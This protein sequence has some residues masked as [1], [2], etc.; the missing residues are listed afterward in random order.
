[1]VSKK[2]MEGSDDGSNEIVSSV[3]TQEN[4]SRN[5]RKFLSEFPLD[6]PIDSPALSLTE[7]PRYE[8]L[9]E[10]LQNTLNE[11]ASLD[12]QSGQT[13]E[14]REIESSQQADWDDPVAC[15]LEKLLISNL[16]A[17]F[18]SAIKKIVE[19]GYSQELAEL[20]VLRSGLYHG[21]KDVVSNVVDGALALLTKERYLG[22]R[23]QVF[24][25]FDSLIEY[26]ILEMICV[27]R[28]V[29]PF[30]TVAEA[31]WYL[32]ICDLNLLHACAVKGDPS[33]EFFSQVN[34]GEGSSD[35]KVPQS[36]TEVS[37]ASSNN[38]KSHLLK[39]SAT[40][41]QS[42]Q[43]K[44]AAS[45]LPKN[46]RFREVAIT[47]KEGSVSLLEMEG[48]SLGASVSEEKSGAG[49][50]GSS[51]L[52]KKDL[53]RQ[54][55][56][57]FEKTYKGRVGKGA[58]FKAKFT[59]WGSMVLDK[60][61][62]PPQSGSSSTAT[63]VT[64]AKITA[65]VKATGLPA[66]GNQHATS[67]PALLI[68]GNDTV[69]A[70]PVQ[71]TIFALRAVNCRKTK[72]SS[73]HVPMPSPKPPGNTSTSSSVSTYYTGIP[74]DE[75]LGKY[76]AQNEK[77]ET[78]LMLIPYIQNLEKQ[79]AVWSDWAA[80]KV[81]MV[82][83]TLTKDQAELRTLRQEKEEVEKFLK[84]KQ[85]LEE[86]TLKRLTE[87]EY[88]I[89]NA[90]GQM[91]MANSSLHR[92]E[93]EHALLQKKMEAAKSHSLESS[94]KSQEAMVREQEALKKCQ[95]GEAEKRLLHE[96][97]SARK[98]E[99]ASLE[100]QLEKAKKRLK[101]IEALA[102][103]EKKEKEELLK[104]AKFLQGK[105]ELMGALAKIE[106]DSIRET[107]EEDMQKCKNEIDKLASEISV[108]ILASEASKIEALRRGIGTGHGSYPK[109]GK[110]GPHIPMTREG[111][112][113]R[114]RECVMCLTEEISVV[115]LPC[116]HQVLCTQ[117]NIRHEKQGMND[118]PSCRTPIKT[119]INVRYSPS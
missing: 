94:R 43:S 67:N 57:H 105:R 63:K 119:R 26:A 37:K 99:R 20:V 33:C 101:Q 77:D 28:E 118:C 85:T 39:S 97:F 45:H 40:S 71:D 17:A 22:T 53:L 87:M 89:S 110:L 70:S 61:L 14:K 30:L 8:L 56:F 108:L 15:E 51:L 72:A 115:F 107:A 112:E 90:S 2:E 65:T 50:K 38:H 91:E 104:Q 27:L 29:K 93:V 18:R 3:S 58:S 102:E 100:Q 114:E 86:N 59:S 4:G 117:C 42:S 25:E 23:Y 34:Q 92:L 55:A 48:K 79:I 6:I 75:S 49:R 54:K 36:K 10:K 19:C 52:S 68:S 74:Y 9:E 78:I 66:E 98:C 7:F 111:G 73:D 76:V 1:M 69:G 80:E 47:G 16:H 106:E 11:F 24:E 13:N 41:S 88:A 12:L 5:K 44:A 31:M 84:D 109:D 113:K 60:T 81:R 83:R 96:K 116:A 21:V 82:A 62:N 35:T 95:A 64:S 46:S 103:Q 32:L